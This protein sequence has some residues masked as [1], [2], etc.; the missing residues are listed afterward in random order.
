MHW[1]DTFE[2]EFQDQLFELYK[3]EWWTKGRSNEDV[4]SA[5]DNSDLVFGCV[6]DDNEL[7]ACSRV[8]SD[9]TFKAIIF[10]FIIAKTHRGQGLGKLMLDQIIGHET[11]ANVKS[12]ELYCPD[13]IAPFYER[14]GFKKSNSN[15]LTLLR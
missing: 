8:L 13:H 6:S 9:Y 14:Y 3:Q 1:L 7:I 15:L 10:D 11:L 12:F 5:F 4:I 2:G